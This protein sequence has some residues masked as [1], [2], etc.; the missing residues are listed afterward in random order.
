MARCG[1]AS[2]CSCLVVG[3]PPI[4]VY[5]N[6][7]P[8]APFT[9]G[10]SYGNQTGCA[11]IAACVADNLGAGLTYD[12]ATAK[13][14]AMISRDPSNGLTFG[15]D[16]GLF[17]AG[18]GGGG[19]TCQKSVA[20][21]PV[22]PG[23]TGAY[24]VAALINPY[25]SPFGL[26]YCLANEIDIVHFIAA[27]TSDNVAW[28][29]EYDAGQVNAGRSS[30]YET[31][32]ARYLDSA[33]IKSVVNYAG[34]PNDPFS[35]GTVA[36][37]VPG[38][39]WY[40]WLAPNYQQPLVSDFLARMDGKAVALIDCHDAGDPTNVE[41]D[42]IQ[43]VLR[44]VRDY[45]AQAWTM[46]G[47]RSIANASTVINAG[48]EPIMMP[49]YPATWGTTTLPYTVAALQAAAIHWIALPYFYADSV[50]TTYKNAGFQVLMTGATRHADKTRLTTLGVRGFLGNDPVYTRGPATR[51]YR[52]A[53]DPWSQRRMGNGQLS[54]ATDLS[55]VAGTG[56]RGYHRRPVSPSI[57]G[58]EGLMIPARFGNGGYSPTILCGWECPLQTPT[59]YTI[60]LEIQY[61]TLP[62]GSPSDRIG[63]LFAMPTD[64]SPF[65]WNGSDGNPTAMPV[66]GAK[67]CYR[68]FQRVNGD[69]G[70]GVF[71]ATGVYSDLVVVASPAIAADVWNTYLLTVTP[72]QLTWRRTTSGGTNYT[73]TIANSVNRGAYFGVEKEELHP[74]NSQYGYIGGFRN[75]KVTG[76]GDD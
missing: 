10:I 20:T 37:R 23:V 51:D 70:I 46:M 7:S 57:T 41:A 4:V 44:A 14:Q 64:V 76:Q 71:S 62:V 40:G 53:Q 25:N 8:G 42:N 27:A 45:C 38:S 55:S 6:G 61:D 29:S 15:S 30:I 5:G 59:A 68:A 9:V 16:S 35:G 18:G 63:L 19:A 12:E 43:A 2:G 72:T 69:I 54:H 3:A 66:N 49:T 75:L 24:S 11:G 52:R 48:V 65:G 17:A 33:T 47:V 36:A 74:E 31:A 28:V 22:A 32:Y 21:L 1:C 56:T 58:L 39:G 67:S 60:S 50:F 13:I 26:E 34:D 73:A